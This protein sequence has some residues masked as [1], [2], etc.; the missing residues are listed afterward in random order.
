M[1]RGRRSVRC[2]KGPVFK[3]LRSIKLA[4]LLV[5]VVIVVG[6]VGYR[7]GGLDWRDALYQTLVT[8]T[9]VG[10]HDLTP[11][12]DMRG[13]TIV[14]VALG[15]L[16]LAMMVSVI[17]GG[18]IEEQ[19]QGFFGRTR[20][21]NR[22]KKLENHF[23]ICGFGRFGRT[24]AQNLQ[25]KNTPFAVLEMD[26]VT[27]EAGGRDGF[28]CLQGDATE[29]DQLTRAGIE[30][31][32]GLLTT[33]DNDAANLYVTLSAKQMNPAAKVVAL[34][35]NE[36]AASKL[37]A[38]GADEVV[39]PYQLGGNWMAQTITSP[40]VTDFMK[41]ATGLNPLNYYMEEVR[42]S[43]SSQIAGQTLRDSPI[44]SEHGAIVLAVRHARGEFVTNPNPDKE[45]R[46]GD[47][48]VV[49]GEQ[50]KLEEL[51]RIAGDT[52]G[53]GGSSA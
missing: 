24:I 10:Y 8:I 40:H 27:V 16:L 33:L 28:L 22:V 11:G 49:L 25:R 47:V 37:R 39:S 46:G 50:A 14:L 23:I 13:F 26:P 6:T 9:T 48:L 52:S 34:A 31:A 53:A 12:E 42:I 38:A 20:V 36:R 3:S 51:K 4:F 1:F 19:L 15:P 18:V 45:L 44:K 43:A 41:M 2:A 29:E 30:R 7:L 17:T 5:G 35:L 32:A 21:E